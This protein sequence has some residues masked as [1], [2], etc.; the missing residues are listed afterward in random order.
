MNEKP[1]APEEQAFVFWTG[2][3][4][5]SFRVLQV[6]LIEKR[7]VL[8]VYV[9]SGE[10]KSMRYEIAAMDAIRRGV[11]E[12]FG[13]EAAARIKPTIYH[14]L[15]G[16]PD[17]ADIQESHDYIVQTHNFGS[18]YKWLANFARYHDYD[19]LE[20]G[21]HAM[22]GPGRW[23]YQWIEENCDFANGTYRISKAPPDP[24]ISAVF[25][26]FSFPMLKMTK[27]DMAQIAQDAGFSDLMTL[28]HFCHRPRNDGSPCGRCMPCQEAIVQG[29]AHRIPRLTRLKMRLR[30]LT[31]VIRR[32]AGI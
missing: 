15:E 1:Q 20:M 7:D 10:R 25:G 29:M 19:N 9:D 21:M 6:A 26:R 4:D 5:S 18:Q 11:A 3:W 16:V 12:K 17:D 24:L 2:G 31:S 30:P 23:P 27:P 13:V 14:T 28:T 32:V 8:P 22:L